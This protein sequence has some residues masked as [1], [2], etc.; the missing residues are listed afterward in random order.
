MT[1][2]Q[3]PVY[4]SIRRQAFPGFVSLPDERII[5]VAPVKRYV[6]GDQDKIIAVLNDGTEIADIDQVEVGTGYRPY[7][8]FVHVLDSTTKQVVPLMNGGIK[9]HRIPSLHRLILY[10]HNPSLA[11]IGTAAISYTPFTIADVCSTWLTLAWRGEVPYPSTTEERLQS[12]T[13]RLN[14]IA[15]SISET[16]NPSSLLSYGVLGSYEE[17]YAAGLK[18]DIVKARPEL[19]EVL[20]EWNPE[21]TIERERMFGAKR[22]ALEYMKQEREALE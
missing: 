6:L 17:T 3:T 20:P 22:K 13:D 10:S 16:E 4:R 21:Q 18:E 9:P 5:D 8:S 19:K 15:K 14:A 2:A 12:E 7:P 1:V 11:F